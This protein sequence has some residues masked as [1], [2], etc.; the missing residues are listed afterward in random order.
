MMKK[1]LIETSLCNPMT[2][3]LKGLTKIV[4]TYMVKFNV[5][6]FF[7]VMVFLF[8]CLFVCFFVNLKYIH[9]PNAI[10]DKVVTKLFTILKKFFF[11]YLN[12]TSYLKSS[13][14]T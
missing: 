2:Y 1:V 8:V 7:N 4:N 3:V 9:K 10:F 5:T 12:P 6:F 13:S 11:P 14:S